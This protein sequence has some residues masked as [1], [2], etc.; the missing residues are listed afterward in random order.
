MKKL[1]E[2]ARQNQAREGTPLVPALRRQSSLVYGEFQDS[3]G[4][5]GKLSQQ[6]TNKI[7]N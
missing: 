6:E 2:T 7:N 4:Y 1:L 3:L 5:T